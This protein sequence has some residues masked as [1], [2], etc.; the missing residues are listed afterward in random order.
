[1]R[2]RYSA[3]FSGGFAFSDLQTAPLRAAYPNVRLRGGSRISDIRRQLGQYRHMVDAQTSVVKLA[4]AN[5]AVP[6]ALALVS[7]FFDWHILFRVIFVLLIIVGVIQHLNEIFRL[8]KYESKVA[9]LEAGS[10]L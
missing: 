2:T 7:F 1:M 6:T 4:W 5:W 8:R 10:S 9:E 3:L